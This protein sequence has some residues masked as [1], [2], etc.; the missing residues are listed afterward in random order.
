MKIITTALEGVLIVEPDIHG[1]KRGFFFETYN[2]KRYSE[3]GIDRIF[4]QDNLSFSKRG[5]L[6]G[7]HFQVKQPQA[8]L[9]QVVQGE[10]FD[11]AV[12]IRISS[13]T[14]GQ[15]TG[16]RLSEE[17]KLQFF[18]PEGFAHGF[19]V[20]SDTAL[21]MYKCSALYDPADE[22]GIIWSD[23]EIAIDWP[24]VDPVVSD[25]DQGYTRLAELR[26]EQLPRIGGSTPCGSH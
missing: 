24:V 21:F 23:P 6:R 18:I 22:G 19:V 20:L 16:A 2:R 8:K 25:K 14:F 5:T 26:P 7:L 1:D 9:V 4:V 11:V 12:D 13:P 10:V 17:N 3:S 15:W